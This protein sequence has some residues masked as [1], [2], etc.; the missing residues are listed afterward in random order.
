MTSG[1]RAACLLEGGLWEGGAGGDICCVC[2]S[3]VRTTGE[4]EGR[5][6]PGI[7]EEKEN[8]TIRWA[9]GTYQ[10]AVGACQTGMVIWSGRAQHLGWPTDLRYGVPRGSRRGRLSFSSSASPP[11]PPPPQ[12]FPLLMDWAAMDLSPERLPLWGGTLKPEV[13][14]PACGTHRGTGIFLG[15]RDACGAG[16]L[17]ALGKEPRL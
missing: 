16:S 9:K 13:P 7:P 3:G 15:G 2:K 8:R 5:S 17:G 1:H 11:L 14:D 10:G 4:G 6:C 12:H